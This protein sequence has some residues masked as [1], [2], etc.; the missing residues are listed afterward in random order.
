MIGIAPPHHMNDRTNS[1]LSTG[2]GAG[3][4]ELP[5]DAS[6]RRK[7][8]LAFA[9]AVLLTSLLGFLSWRVAQRAADDASW[10]SHT[11][12]VMTMLEATVQHLVEVETAG[13]VFAL[14][15]HEVFLEPYEPG[16][17]AVHQ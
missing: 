3:V 10:V 17:R 13:R 1:S 8:T 2:F 15:G 6:L 7:V 11:H 5:A 16:R 4:Q 14:T 12:E 9:F